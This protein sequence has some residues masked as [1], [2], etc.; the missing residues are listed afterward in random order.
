MDWQIDNFLG[1]TDAVCDDFRWVAMGCDE[2]RIPATRNPLGKTYYF[3]TWSRPKP[4]P[5]RIRPQSD[6]KVT[7]KWPKVPQSHPKMTKSDPKVTQSDPKMPP[8]C[9]QSDPKVT[10]MQPKC[11][12]NCSCKCTCDLKFNCKCNTNIAVRFASDRKQWS[13]YLIR[14]TDGMSIDR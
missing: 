2:L 7:P 1:W 10:H 14:A 4:D 8:K 12:C 5:T 3:C 6:P 9:P 13:C 11:E